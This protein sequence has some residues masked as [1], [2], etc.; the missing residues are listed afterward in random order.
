MA[1]CEALRQLLTREQVR[2]EVLPHAQVFTAQEVAATSHVPGWH[3]AKVVILRDDAG[4]SLMA[5]IPAPAR[6]DLPALEALAGRRL[7]LAR[8][9]EFGPLFVDCEAG[10]MPPFGSLYGMPLYL[11]ASLALPREFLFQA[12]SHKEVVRMRYD[13]YARLAQPVVGAFSVAAVAPERG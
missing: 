10:A 7:R 6:L 9:D 5:A 8:E 4:G 3:L 1:V 11:D 13:D 12:G 2:F